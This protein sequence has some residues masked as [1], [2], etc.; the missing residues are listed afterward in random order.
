ARM[1]LE[2]RQAGLVVPAVAVQHGPQ[3]SFVYVVATD[4]TAQM[5]PVTVALITGDVAV[6][7]KGL[8]G[9]EQV[10]IEGQNQLRPGGQ[11]EPVKP[12][13]EGKRGSGDAPHKPGGGSGDAHGRG[14]GAPPAAVP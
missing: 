7:D 13:G 14:S 11:D 12:G 3:G 1:L 5:K 4:H 8:D 10:G 9:G 6:I 2:T